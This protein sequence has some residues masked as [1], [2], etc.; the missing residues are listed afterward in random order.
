MLARRSLLSLLA[1]C[2]AACA[3]S[4]SHQPFERLDEDTGMTV[5]G[6]GRPLEFVESGL[7]SI[8]KH[9]SFA[10]LGPVE[11]DRMGQIS[12][13][14]WLHIAPGNDRP[15]ASIDAP[16]AVSLTLDDGDLVLERM[17]PPK[18]G[19]EAYAAL[20]PW[21]QTAYFQASPAMLRRIAASDQLLVRCRGEDGT[22]VEF[23]PDQASKPVLAT[24][25]QARGI[26]AD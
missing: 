12:Y 26:T 1:A 15:V 14:L 17:T 11:W 19:K 3:S 7:L 10:Y 23:K 18:L 25:L 20:V 13:G 22:A 2:L 16:S 24:F 4:A 6:L 9:A 5:S 21:G 8:N